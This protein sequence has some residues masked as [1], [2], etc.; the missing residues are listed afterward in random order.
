MD[1]SDFERSLKIFASDC[2]VDAVVVLTVLVNEDGSVNRQLGI[3]STSRVYR[4]Q[5]SSVTNS[6]DLGH[7][8]VLY[9]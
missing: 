8:C 3:F 9:I 5:V 2:G 1:R 6:P 4:E 7:V